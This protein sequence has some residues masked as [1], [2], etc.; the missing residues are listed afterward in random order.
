MYE[1]PTP[2][3]IQLSVRLAGGAATI[4]AEERDTAVVTVEPYDSSDASH[5]QAENTRVSFQGDRLVVHAPETGFLWRRGNVRVTAQVPID[6]A[7]EC[8]VASADTV[9][10]GRWRE[11]NVTTASG[12][13]EVGVV[14][15]SLKVVTASGDVQV[16]AVGRDLQLRSASGDVEVGTVAGDASLTS[17][18][19]DLTVHDTGGSASA[20]TASGD[21]EVLRARQGEVRAQTASGDVQVSVLP[22]TGVYLDVHTLSGSTHSDLNVGAAP[23]GEVA[24]TSTLSVR[25]HTASGDVAVVRAQ[26]VNGDYTKTA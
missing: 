5:Q 13:L 26:P 9:L 18:S 16:E 11:G 17:A 24:S 20:R 6:S 25:V 14:T 10:A 23:T 2:G 19:G 22:G 8:I 12:D 7:F 3:P 15:G 1:F 4:S 21:I